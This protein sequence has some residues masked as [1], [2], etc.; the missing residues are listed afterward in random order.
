M[1]EPAAIADSGPL[2]ALARIN[3][4]ELLPKLFSKIVKKIKPSLQALPENGIYIREELL[5]AVLKEANE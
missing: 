1:R 2:I 3:Q 5:N 4:L